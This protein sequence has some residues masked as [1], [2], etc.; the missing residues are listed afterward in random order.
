MTYEVEVA[1][2][3]ARVAFRVYVDMAQVEYPLSH[4]EVVLWSPGYFYRG[5]LL[6]AAVTSSVGT[7]T[8]LVV[9]NSFC[10]FLAFFAIKRG[11]KFDSAELFLEKDELLT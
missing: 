10:V 1:F 4:R 2:W 8:V 5:I 7:S 3:L 11:K 9:L 6:L